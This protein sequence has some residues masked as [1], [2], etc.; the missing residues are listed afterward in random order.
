MDAWDVLTNGFE[1]AHEV[2]GSLLDGSP[3]LLGAPPGANTPAW[4][5]WHLTRVE[6][7]HTA[8][9]FGLEQVWT[10]GWADR[11]ALPFSAEATGYGM[12]PAEVRKVH[13]SPD[14]LLG[15]C[16]DVHQRTVK[17]LAGKPDLDRVVDDSFDPPVTLGVRLVSVLSDQLQHVGQAAYVL[18]LS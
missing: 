10:T 7:G 13:A 16:E 6:D 5:I 17:A 9:A 14:L 3:D 12:S 1:R 15:Y 8:E 11:F 18:G 2:V 4:L